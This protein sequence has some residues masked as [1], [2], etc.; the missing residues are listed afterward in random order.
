MKKIIGLLLGLASVF[1]L[2]SCDLSALM[3][4][5]TSESVQTESVTSEES[6]EHK[7]KLTRVSERAATCV[8]EGNITHWTCDCGAYFADAMGAEEITA[9][10]VVLAKKEHNLKHTEGYEATCIS[11]GKV[12]NWYC[13][14][15]KNYYADEACTEVIKAT[16]IILQTVSHDLTHHAETPVNGKENG[17]KE[18]WTCSYCMGYFLNEEGTKKT[19]A[20]KVVLYSPLAIPDFL[21]EVP[22]GREPVVLQLTDTQIMDSSQ[23]LNGVLG[24]SQPS[25]YAPS[26]MNARC[27]DYLTDIITA[28]NPDLIILT[29]DNIYGKFDHNG[30]V[31]TAFVNFMDSFDIPWAPIFG[32]HDNESNMGVDWQCEQLMKAENCL[33]MQRTL[34]G[35]CNYSVAITQGGEIKRVFYMLDSNGIGSPSAAT[36]AN[37]HTSTTPGFGSDQIVWYTEQ[38]ERMQELLPDV[39]V[40]FAYHIQSNLFEVAY[41]KYGYVN[42]TPWANINVDLHEEKAE[43]DFGYIGYVKGEWTQDIK[44]LKRL[45]VDSIFVGHEHTSS[46]SVVYQGI[47]FQFGQKSSRYDMFSVLDAAGNVKHTDYEAASDSPLIGGSVIVLSEEDGAIADAYIYYCDDNHGKIANG[48]IQWASFLPATVEAVLPGKAYSPNGKNED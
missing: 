23:D 48:E 10:D 9:A 30:S 17:V 14:D 6:S 31:W 29:G 5:T 36:L 25:M 1:T 12:E 8:Q 22:V 19:T 15:C 7:H 21:V 27:F 13:S 46:A 24:G 40:S 38:I 34:T 45:G 4:G 43:G 26:Q 42:W 18:H 47:R 11:K 37:G 41:A 39:K 28:T 32:N 33:F 2:A 20:D 44:E 3:G 35:N 16:Q